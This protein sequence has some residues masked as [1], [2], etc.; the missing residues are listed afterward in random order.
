MYLTSS[1]EEQLI[2][3]Y[4]KVL[5]S[6]VHRFKRKMRGGYNNQEDLH[7]E[8]VLVFIKHIRSCE[9][10]EE[11]HKIPVLN[12][13]NAMCNFVLGE[14][15]LSYPKRTAN[16]RAVMENVSVKVEYS[17]AHFA[18]EHASDPLGDSVDRIFFSEYLDTLSNQ[19]RQIIAM[20]LRGCRNREAASALGMSDVAMTRALKRLRK[21]YEAMAQA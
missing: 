17:E 19:D 7:S 13:I 9:T 18:Q 3:Q 20:K 4:D 11:I 8:C 5:W 6:V 21:H 15:A 14:Q 16:F 10:M 12:M 2:Q 1:Q